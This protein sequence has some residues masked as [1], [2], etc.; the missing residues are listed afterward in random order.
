MEAMALPF[1]V[2]PQPLAIN[3][4]Q[5]VSCK[6]QMMEKHALS[7]ADLVAERLAVGARKRHQLSPAK[8]KINTAP[9]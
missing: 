6:K 1:L 3:L 4:H 2:T 8:Y 7:V 9:T 5:G